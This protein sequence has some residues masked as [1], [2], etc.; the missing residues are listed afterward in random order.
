MQA[1]KKHALTSYIDTPKEKKEKKGK[2]KKKNEKFY[3]K[4]PHKTEMIM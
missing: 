2:T 4:V 1:W 3:E